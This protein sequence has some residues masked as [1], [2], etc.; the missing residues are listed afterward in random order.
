MK[1]GTCQLCG[2]T[3]DL[4]KAHIIPRTIFSKTR[5]EGAP[6]QL[7][8][9]WEGNQGN[10]SEGFIDKSILCG[11]CDSSFSEAEKY[12]GEYLHSNHNAASQAHNGVTAFIDEAYDYE[13]L[14][15][16]ILVTLWRAAISSNEA[17]CDVYMEKEEKEKLRKMLVKGE[18]GAAGCFPVVISRWKSNEKFERVCR[19]T[20]MEPRVIKKSYCETCFLGWKVLISI[21][22][23]ANDN[24]LFKNA[25][26]EDKLVAIDQAFETSDFFK[27]LMELSLNSN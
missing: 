8:T 17:F 26:S 25:I 24:A 9:S 19:E 2:D 20:V 27:R 3:K 10:K 7:L 6:P 23:N 14:K 15:L 4:I 21:K 1:K 22:E 16:A 11:D 18:V 5:G 12:L 13:K